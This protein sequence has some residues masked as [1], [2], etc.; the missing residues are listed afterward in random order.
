[1]DKFQKQ[2]SGF[3]SIFT[4]HMKLISSEVANTKGLSFEFSDKEV[5]LNAEQIQHRKDN[6]YLALILGNNYN[7]NIRI[8]AHTSQG[9]QLIEGVMLALTEEFVIFKGGGKVPVPC[10]EEIRIY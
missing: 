8:S 7:K 2:N 6:L 4:M 9:I 1:M 10:I 5:L 3:F